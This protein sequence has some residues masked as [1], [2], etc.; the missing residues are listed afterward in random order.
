LTSEELK[1]AINKGDGNKAPGRDGIGLGLFKS[2]WDAFTKDWLNLFSQMFTTNNVFEQ[3]KRGVIVFIP[4]TVMPHQPSDYRQI[5]L[6]NTD[7]KILA[8]IMAYRI[9]HTLEKLLHASQ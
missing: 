4:K 3:Q 1:A 5:T 7:Y 6:L 8:R 2:T 9:R